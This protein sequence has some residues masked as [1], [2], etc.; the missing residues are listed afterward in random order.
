MTREQYQSKY[1]SVSDE[2][3]KAL[4]EKGLVPDK[5]SPHAQQKFKE[6]MS[7]EPKKDKQTFTND[8]MIF[9]GGMDLVLF[10]DRFP[11][12]ADQYMYNF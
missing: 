6:L 2:K 5:N 9:L 1:W 4:T 12:D 11:I 3:W 8:E 10:G 7:K